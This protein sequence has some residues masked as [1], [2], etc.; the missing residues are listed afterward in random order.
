MNRQPLTGLVAVVGRRKAP[1]PEDMN[2]AYRVGII[3]AE[4]NLTVVTGG[5][6]GIMEAAALGVR[7]GRGRILAI[8]P[9]DELPIGLFDLAVRTGLTPTVRNVVIGS[10]CD[11]MVALPGSHG[12]WQEM[13]VALDRGIP[14]LAIGPHEEQ[15]PGVT[16]VTECELKPRLA[17]ILD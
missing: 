16:E 13:A 7:F 4:L 15:L 2:L 8:T 12:T 9:L 10:C 6:G 3:C 5:R 1:P 11:V 17:S 14:V